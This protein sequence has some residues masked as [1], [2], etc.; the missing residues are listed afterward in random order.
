MRFLEG[1]CAASTLFIFVAASPVD[2]QPRAGNFIVHQTT[3]KP[4]KKSG[5]A[6]ILSTYGKYNASAPE[7]VIKAATANDGKVSANPT[8][9][10]TEYLSP[11]NIGGQTLNLDFDTGSSDLWVYSSNLP[12][13]QSNGHSVYNPT[14]SS[15][16]KKLD[17]YTW[18][19]LYGDGSGAS[20]DVGTDTVKIG[21]TTVTGQA[22][23]LAD[24]ISY[25]FKNDIDNDGI[26]GLGFDSIN[27]VVQPVRQKTFFSNAKASLSAPLF[28]A[29]LK[30]GK[31]GCY[32]FGYV[33]A[34]EYTG[35]ITYVPANSDNGFWEFTSN[36]YAVGTAAFR[37]FSFIANPDTGTT[38]VYLPDAIVRAYYGSVRGSG[39]N[40]AE[41]GYTY[42]CSAN[43]PSLTIGIGTYRAVI[44][45]SYIT[46]A[47]VNSITCFGGI[48]SNNGLGTAVL[49]DIFLKSQF[50]VFQTSPLQLGFARKPL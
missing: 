6:A 11:V 45:S 7:E 16:S 37:S 26:L 50:V 3:P 42:P 38:L 18:E 23:E 49:G 48:Q 15:T 25:Q 2:L 43:L 32:T 47:P 4:F 44:P 20:G 8:L 29:N 46:Y 35:S 24:E 28:T 22:V 14:L 30:K 31:P 36:G 9:F 5:P 41:G 17:G 12:T 10:D 27:T 34:A 1:L 39:Y 19:I 33:N 40:Y 13:S 21:T